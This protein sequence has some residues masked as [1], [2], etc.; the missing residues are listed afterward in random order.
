V[1]VSPFQWSWFCSLPIEFAR[2]ILLWNP[3][4]SEPSTASPV[5]ARH[6]NLG[7][8]EAFKFRC[9]GA[10]AAS[11]LTGNT[12]SPVAVRR[13]NSREGE[14][15]E[16]RRPD[17]QADCDIADP[18]AHFRIA[19][20]CPASEFEGGRGP[21]IQVPGRTGKVKV[22]TQAR[23]M[24]VFGL[25]NRQD[26]DKQSFNIARCCPASEFG[27]GRGLQVQVP[28]RTVRRFFSLVDSQDNAFQ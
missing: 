20:C 16:F 14:A 19:R 12:I 18:T 22:C 7:E 4:P 11:S 25:M 28:G 13:L 8:G 26:V 15:R 5:A 17:A 2:S 6:L 21:R 9:P 1:P 23:T 27:G 3:H 10:Q 24:R